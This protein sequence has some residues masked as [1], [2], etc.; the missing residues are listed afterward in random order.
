VTEFLSRKVPFWKMHAI[1]EYNT[2]GGQRESGCTVLAKRIVNV[3]RRKALQSTVIDE[4]F[5]R[6][7]DENYIVARWCANNHLYTDF[8]WLIVHAVEKYLK[9]VLLY[10][11]RSVLSY[12]HNI[13][14]LYDILAGF[15]GKLLP[16]ELSVPEWCTALPNT[17]PTRQFVAYLF[18]RGNADNRYALHGYTSQLPRDLF[19][20]DSLVFAVRR[21][22]CPLNDRAFPERVR[23]APPITNRQ[24]LAKEPHDFRRLGMPLEALIAETKNS[25][26]RTAALNQNLPFA[27]PD[28]PHIALQEIERAIRN[29]II[30]HRIFG[31]LQSS[32][33][34]PVAEGLAVAKWIVKNVRLPNGLDEQIRDGIRIAERKLKSSRRARRPPV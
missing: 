15:A 17:L 21:L 10:N 22:I 29:P 2:A 7:A 33:R 30:D 19:M 25:P 20:A 1:A 23:T 34:Y 12:S 6:T 9:A 26:A 11:G 16:K 4:L 24:L 31:P 8:F 14:A 18:R 28:F 5:V 3:A 32:E 13:V 27:P